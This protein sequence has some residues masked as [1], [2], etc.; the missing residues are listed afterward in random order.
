[1]LPKYKGINVRKYRTVT[2]SFMYG[3]DEP[4]ILAKFIHS[5]IH[6]LNHSM[7]IKYLHSELC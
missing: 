1:M 4:R 5:L 3:K 2:P 7:F 6:S